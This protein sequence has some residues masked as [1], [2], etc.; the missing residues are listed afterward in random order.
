[1]NERFLHAQDVA[2]LLNV[3]IAT[4]YR[5]CRRG[6]LV[7]VRLGEGRQRPLV[8]FRREDLDRFLRERTVGPSTS[9]S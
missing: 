4:V 8:R 7:H 9:A 2:R 3:K 5:L 6:E 1:M